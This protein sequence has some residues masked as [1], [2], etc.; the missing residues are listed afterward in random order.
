[1]NKSLFSLM[2]PSAVCVVES[3]VDH[4]INSN[5]QM[6]LKIYNS[7]LVDNFAGIMVES[8]EIAKYLCVFGKQ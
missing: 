4:F 8:L 1:L 6:L 2:S 3:I 5:F 7:L